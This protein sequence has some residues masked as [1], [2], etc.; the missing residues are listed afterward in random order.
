[1]IIPPYLK[2]NDTIGMICPSG[3]MPIEKTL[4]SQQSLAEWGFKIKMGSTVGSQYNYFSGDDK[5]RLQDLQQ[6]LDDK[7]I[8]AIFCARG[9]YGLT[10]IIDR[11][12]FKKFKAFPKW[13]VGFSDITV[14]HYHLLAKLKTACLHAPMAAAF[15][16]EGYK[17]IFVNSLK[18]SLSGK[19]CNYEC[20]PHLFNKTGKAEGRLIGGNLSLIA[21]L[22]GTKS[23]V[24]TKGK[25]LFIEDV[26]EYIYNVDRMLYQLKRSGQLKGLAGLIVG[27]F[28]EMIDTTIP[29]GQSATEVIR[30]IVSEYD[31]PV[32]F[33]FPV[34][35]NTENYALKCGIKHKLTVAHDKVRLVEAED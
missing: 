35:H 17:N 12:S 22:T 25:I 31:Y 13:I 33:D 29:Y 19:P 14:L 3:F 21:H 23:Q 5:Q 10:R 7:E 9:G 11:L 1:M 32:C 28:T 4:Q 6:M 2:K 26:G 30:D 24:K 34:S 8:K 18:E 15:N 27:G 16:E 20:S